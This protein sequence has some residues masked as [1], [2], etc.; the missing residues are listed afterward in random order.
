[1]PPSRRKPADTGGFSLIETLVALLIAG[2]AMAATAEVF[3]NGLLG[4]QASEDAATA[5]SIAEGQIA[6]AAASDPMTP[7][8]SEGMFGGRY[9]WLLT[10]TPYDDPQK[11]TAA[12]GFTQPAT[13]TG[14]RLYRIA[15]AVDWR[16]GWR[17]RQVALATLR[18]RPTPP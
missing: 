11:D 12:A 5:L 7:R 15:V 1:V 13:A 6:V 9:H 18:L 8:Q 10:V 17:Q 4:H 2:L 14:L 3:G 16:A